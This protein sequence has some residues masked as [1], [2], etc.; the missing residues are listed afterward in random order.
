[1]AD[2]S[3]KVVVSATV[4]GLVTGMRTA[5]KATADYAKSAMGYYQK[6]QQALD[7]IGNTAL[8]VGAGL[9]ALA[10]YAV[11]SAMDW[12]QAWTGV[13]KTVDGTPEQLAAVENGLRDL[14]V[15][16]GFAHTEVAAVAE[17]AGQLGISTG[18]IT[19]FTETM[20][21]MGVSTSLT[22]EEAATGLA[23]LRNILGSSESE[24]GNM[25]ST[26]VA[27]GNNFATTE[28]EILDMSLRLAGAGKQAGLTEADVMGLAASMSSVGIESEAGGTAMSMVLKRIG[29]EVETNGP[30]LDLFAQTAGMSAEQFKGAWETDA[31]GALT[32][33][34]D[35]L[36]KAETMGMSTNAV[37]RELGVTGIRE[38]DALLRLSGNAEG[39]ADALGMAEEGWRQN[40]ALMEEA[41]KFYGT[42]AQKG[43]QALSAI[44]DSAIDAGD[45]LLP[46]VA[47]MAEG[48]AGL[49]GA[50]GSLPGPIK[51]GIT[52][53]AGV[54]GVS[55]LAVGGML[56]LVGAISS[57][58][59]QI[60]ALNASGSAGSRGLGML[61]TGAGKA[62][63]A[64]SGLLVAQ[65]VIES[66]ADR[67]PAEIAKLSKELEK[68]GQSGKVGKELRDTFGK[69]LGGDGRFLADVRS[70]GEAIGQFDKYSDDNAVTRLAR[71]VKDRGFGST[72]RDQV[73]TIKDMDAALTQLS[74]NKPDQA[75]AA[76]E[77]LRDSALDQGAS[78][79]EVSRAFPAMTEIL[80]GASES[81]GG[82]ADATEVLNGNL[83]DLAPTAQ[84][85]AEE[86]AKMEERAQGIGESFTAFGDNLDDSKVSL[87]SWTQS[88][89]DQADALSDFAD[90]ALEAARRGLD[91][92]LI[93]SLEDAGPAGALRLGQ[94]ADASETEIERANRAFES[95]QDAI[96]RFVAQATNVPYDIVTEFK[97]AGAPDAINTAV[98][99]AEKYELTP[100]TVETI[101]RALDYSSDD[102]KTVR[103]RLNGLDGNDATVYVRANTDAAKAAIR[104]IYDFA[105]S[106]PFINIKAKSGGVTGLRVPQGF[107]S[108]GVVPG[109]P[110]ADKSVDN[111]FA[112]GAAS[113]TPFMV[114]SG[115]WIINQKQSEANDKWLAAIN[116]GLVLDDV[117]GGITGFAAGGQVDAVSALELTQMQ[118]RV[119]NLERSLR[120]RE[121]YGKGKKKRTRYVLR[122]LDRTEA[123][124]ELTEARQEL[125][126]ARVANRSIPRGMTAEQ[127]NTTRDAR[128]AS[129]D[130]YR[131]NVS[132]DGLRTPE[133]VERSLTQTIANMAT[134]TQL[135]IQ[136]KQKGAAPWLLAQLQAMGPTKGTI[137]L[138]RRY[139]SDTA[140]LASVNAQ[141]NQL[142]QVSSIYGQVTGDAKWES[143]KAW[144]GGLSAAQSRTLQVVATTVDPS[145]IAQEVT[146]RV[147]HELE[148]MGQGAGV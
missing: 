108:G 136:L 89:Q 36:G 42:T 32:S 28:G 64:V 23:R 138:A 17:A 18:G 5:Q 120:E 129:A 14:A 2:R 119:R 13:L 26:M 125:S 19:K 110:P 75:I 54:S 24:I 111:V 34:V 128:S 109:T 45:A 98:E 148:S 43:K 66:I 81:M 94:L 97:V 131:D 8:K 78:V 65:S 58:S 145:A 122:G 127:W 27:L 143:N 56:K 76:F 135:L 72:I 96:A 103:D 41:D 126:S 82:T 146:R 86:I 83:S 68:L 10:G 107:A 53:I 69:G 112:M 48:V 144:S 40:V 133:Q 147:V 139:L 113:K 70:L 117:F 49:A 123:R 21:A 29:K 59:E 15:T 6:N 116:G 35:G 115:E 46:T 47:K 102:I 1:M 91:E 22:S 9:T 30:K 57:V 99:I 38:A 121:K 134:F 132:I 84:Q 39:L 77:K 79:E 62:A 51:G 130:S 20:L 141:A 118:I 61:A 92:G 137:G 85:S 80:R 31:A 114:R 37:L 63:V 7:E 33:F 93:Q 105:N 104:G 50:F 60:K 124:L 142:A 11:K 3:V 25:G 52:A 12:E 100:E 95:G 55:L 44:R 73:E 87:S 16:T 74:R 4:T 140:A 106:L 90:N 88:L 71:D 67:N 101:L